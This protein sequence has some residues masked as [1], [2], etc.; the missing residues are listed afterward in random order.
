MK[1]NV[2]DSLLLIQMFLLKSVWASLKDEPEQN[3]NENDDI[4]SINAS[5]Y[6]NLTMVQDY[7]SLLSLTSLGDVSNEKMLLAE[8]RRD[9]LAIFN[10]SSSTT[11]HLIQLFKEIVMFQ[12]IFLRKNV[13]LQLILTNIKDNTRDLPIINIRETWKEF[14][15]ELDSLFDKIFMLERIDFSLFSNPKENYVLFEAS[16]LPGSPFY[17]D[18]SKA[19]KQ[20]Q[21]YGKGGAAK[22]SLLDDFMIQ[23]LVDLLGVN[24]MYIPF[25][26]SVIHKPIMLVTQQIQAIYKQ[27]S[28]HELFQ[29]QQV[30]REEFV[31]LNFII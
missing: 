1:R 28:V 24:F 13:L 19:K 25:V 8:K 6:H 18:D 9:L 3:Y 5:L 20:S 17:D 10:Y 26:L 29:S 12:I 15:L 30:I 27:T 7:N 16:L 4:T 23:K 11:R 21:Y 31:L 22:R 14:I 2:H